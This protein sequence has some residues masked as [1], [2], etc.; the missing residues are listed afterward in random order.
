MDRLPVLRITMFSAAL[1]VALAACSTPGANRPETRI[2]ATSNDTADATFNAMI[3]E[4]SASE[5]EALMVAMLKINFAGVQSAFEV[6]RN[7]DLRKPS[8]A[9]I[10][11]RVAGMTADEIIEYSE[12]VS[13]VETIIERR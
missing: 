3:R 4:A 13:T 10:K 6:A 7:P 11:D 9:R 5:R 2:D 8:I 12:K 1:T